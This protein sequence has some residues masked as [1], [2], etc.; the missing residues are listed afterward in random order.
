M[1]LKTQLFSDLAFLGWE[2]VMSL[3]GHWIGK[4]WN[5]RTFGEPCVNYYTIID[6]VVN[7]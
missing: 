5:L 2:M 4:C 3:V 1:D 7:V 6:N